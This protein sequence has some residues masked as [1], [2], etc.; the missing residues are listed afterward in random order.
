MPSLCFTKKWIYHAEKDMK[1]KTLSDHRSYV[2]N[3]SN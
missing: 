1:T 3:L 2:D